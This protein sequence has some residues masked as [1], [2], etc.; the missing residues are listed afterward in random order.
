LYDFFLRHHTH[1]ERNAGSQ[2]LAASRVSGRDMVGSIAYTLRLWD[3][4]TLSL[5][6][7]DLPLDNNAAERALCPVVIG[8]K[9]GYFVGSEDAGTWAAIFFSHI[10]SCRMLKWTIGAT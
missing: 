6:H 5:N 8:R 1:L 7:G 10:E 3:A 4:L 2:D 9:N